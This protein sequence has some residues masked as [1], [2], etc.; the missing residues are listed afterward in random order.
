MPGYNQHTISLNKIRELPY[1][2]RMRLIFV[3]G[4]DVEEIVRLINDYPD[5]DHEELEHKIVEVWKPN[6][7][8]TIHPCIDKLKNKVNISR[9]IY[10]FFKKGFEEMN[11]STIVYFLYNKSL[12]NDEFYM[13]SIFDIIISGLSKSNKKNIIIMV[14][15]RSVGSTGQSLMS[16]GNGDL[17]W[18]GPK[19]LADIFYAF[20][21]P[22][23]I[24][25]I[26]WDKLIHTTIL[27]L[28]NEY[29]YSFAHKL[30]NYIKDPVLL[31]NLQNGLNIHDILV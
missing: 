23:W 19:T 6:I 5:W 8:T 24:K 28:D 11:I 18:A 13:S 14:K 21:E 10:L 31:N 27:Y 1:N 26:D 25:I 9:L 2:E 3:N 17:F 20:L 7:L 30:K 15:G 16:N 22:N 4:G 29:I 12:N